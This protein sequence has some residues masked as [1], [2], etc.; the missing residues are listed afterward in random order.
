MNGTVI[1]NNSK[2]ISFLGEIRGLTEGE[3]LPAFTGIVT[4]YFDDLKKPFQHNKLVVIAQA[5]YS[6]LYIHKNFRQK[7]CH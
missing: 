3:A 1:T 6:G 4:D 2:R 5:D 7:R